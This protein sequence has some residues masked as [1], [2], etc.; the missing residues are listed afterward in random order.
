MKKI[1]LIIIMMF[2]CVVNINADSIELNSDGV[3][4]NGS[5]METCKDYQGYVACHMNNNDMGYRYTIIGSNGYKIANTNSVDYFDDYAQTSVPA[6]KNTNMNNSIYYFR[7]GKYYTLSTS[8]MTTYYKNYKISNGTLGSTTSSF[9]RLNL[10]GKQ[11]LDWKKGIVNLGNMVNEVI[12]GE[13]LFESIL[14]DTRFANDLN[15]STR[16]KEF[17]Q[18]NYK[19]LIEPIYVIY[20]NTSANSTE[21]KYVMGTTSE[22]AKHIRTEYI[23]NYSKS[24]K[25]HFHM[26]LTVN[27]IPNLAYNVCSGSVCYPQ[28][29]KV[30][31]QNKNNSAYNENHYKTVIDNLYEI[32]T[33]YGYGT[34]TISG[35]EIDIETVDTCVTDFKKLIDN[36]NPVHRIEL[37]QKYKTRTNLLNFDI[38]DPNEACSAASCNSL[39]LGCIS[40]GFNSNF[41]ATNLSCYAESIEIEGL[42]AFCGYEFNLSS[43]LTS[44]SGFGKIKA[45]Q[46]LLYSPTKKPVAT[47]TLTKKCFAYAAENAEPSIK[48]DKIS[49]FEIGDI[50][51]DIDYLYIDGEKLESEVIN[52]Q[53]DSLERN[54][55][56]K[57]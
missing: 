52:A 50:N 56:E 10:G 33:T 46:L 48:S 37:F 17:A 49:A 25:G 1:L 30:S 27:F 44:N 13:D 20:Y 9:K 35:K 3:T 28:T 32:Y 36:K 55:T 4:S 53:V 5:K 18:G 16:K 26:G 39:G 15:I 21:Y 11:Y 8:K 31:S 38:T 42:T 51:S 14:I 34:T 54:F 24:N 2:M 19:I 23:D 7:N 40:G 29:I 22:I 43:S 57:K 45:G 47:A 6:L 12:K 41:S